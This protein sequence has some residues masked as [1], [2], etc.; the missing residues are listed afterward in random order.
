MNVENNQLRGLW[1]A[2]LFCLASSCSVQDRSGYKYESAQGGATEGGA[3][4]GG[5]PSGG[6]Q[7]HGGVSVNEGG[8]QDSSR[9]GAGLVSGSGGFATGGTNNASAGESGG[10]SGAGGVSTPMEG[11]ASAGAQAAGASAGLAGAN[12]TGGRVGSGGS[13]SAG[14]TAAG[15]ASAGQA[16]GGAAGGDGCNQQL[17]Q[18]AGF[19]QGNTTW[20]LESDFPGIAAIVPGSDSGLKA[21]GVAPKEGNYLAW[22]G[23]IPDNKFESYYVSISQVIQIPAGT[24]MLTLTGF[25]R[26]KTEEPDV[27]N[28]YDRAFIQLEWPDDR[29]DLLWLP[30]EW[31]IDQANSD[32]VQFSAV[33]TETAQIAGQRV[34]LRARA[35]T[36][37]NLKS[38]FWLDS[39]SLV[40]KCGR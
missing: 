12:A 5:G 6:A 32:W 9:G 8:K 34:M 37:P 22:L 29:P 20:L 40:A 4:S 17:L 7:A 30:V 25:I 13:S 16:N 21:E 38:S 24:S 26:I 28:T 39:L 23:G 11:G 27:H 35:E 1:C 36:D 18:N 15:A 31:T 3:P 33:K 2:V 10:L 19:E 14:T